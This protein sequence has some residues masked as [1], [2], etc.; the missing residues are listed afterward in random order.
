MSERTMEKARQV[1]HRL[2]EGYFAEGGDNDPDS[3][4]DREDLDA[5][6]DLVRTAEASVRRELEASG[7]GE[8][9]RE[10]V[11]REVFALDED[12][13][14]EYWLQFRREFTRQAQAYYDTADRILALLRTPRGEWEAEPV[15]WRV[16]F[17]PRGEIE[18]QRLGTYDYPDIAEDRALILSSSG[19]MECRIVPLYPAEAYN[20]AHAARRSK[21]G[22]A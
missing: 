19:R 11:A 12:W 21:G 17:R 13:R 20:E 16:E 3:P 18:W 8:D 7:A 15:A 2:S 1:V 5:L 10:L 9:V 14:R 22:R 4:I 6:H